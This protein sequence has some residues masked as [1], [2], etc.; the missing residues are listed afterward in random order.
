MFL[1]YL[2][3]PRGLL[4]HIKVNNEIIGYCGVLKTKMAGIEGSSTTM[5]QYLFGCLIKAL[6]CRPW[7]AFHKDNFKRIPLIKKNLLLKLGIKK[8]VK[9]KTLQEDS[10]EPFWG[11]V[12]I[13]VN[14]TF[15]SKGIGT[16]LLQ[17]FERLA[18]EEG[19]GKLVLSVNSGNAKAIKSYKRNNWEINQN[20][21]QST[22]MLK[23][24]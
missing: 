24:I 16:L 10:F 5:S 21:G 11:L 22:T 2:E 8:K 6:L 4:F 13:G 14:P 3:N 7:V 18:K 15:Q 20:N 23:K 1:F 17:E 19:F 12:V 9:S